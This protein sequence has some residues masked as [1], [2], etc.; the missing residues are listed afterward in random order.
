M[1][2]GVAPGMDNILLG[3]HHRRM[4]VNRFVCLV[5]GLPKHRQWPYEYKAL[6][7]IDVLEEYTRPARYVQDGKEVV[8][9]A[10]SEPELM[11]LQKWVP[12]KL[13]TATDCAA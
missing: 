4:Q 1:D 6:F 2:V 9:P 5:G 10:L 8:M 7:P 11:E 13:S 12:S 3:Y